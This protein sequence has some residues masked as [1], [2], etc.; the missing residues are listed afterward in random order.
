MAARSWNPNEVLK[1]GPI[2]DGFTCVG[3]TRIREDCQCRIKK[4]KR[5]EARLLL[6]KMSSIDLCADD[7]DHLLGDLA[8][9]TLCHRHAKGKGKKQDQHDDMVQHWLV[10]MMKEANRARRGGDTIMGQP[11][12]N[13]AHLFGDIDEI[14][15]RLE[16]L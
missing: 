1:I 8:E 4:S 11:G 3:K 6:T 9:L 14:G 15:E 7:Q 5:D 13:R 10:L 12:D 16:R 2:T